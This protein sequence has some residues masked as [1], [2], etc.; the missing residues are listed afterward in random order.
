[1]SDYLIC[2]LG[3]YVRY[4][5]ACLVSWSRSNWFCN[6]MLVFMIG[7]ATAWLCIFYMPIIII[8]G[9]WLCH[10]WEYLQIKKKEWKLSWFIFIVQASCHFWPLNNNTHWKTD[11]A[12]HKI[13]GSSSWTLNRDWTFDLWLWSRH[14]PYW[15]TR[16]QTDT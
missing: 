10:V 9:L 3:H 1:M 11:R 6:F 14:L 12:K 4:D 5:A 15:V 16:L 8:H 7:A 13:L 2:V